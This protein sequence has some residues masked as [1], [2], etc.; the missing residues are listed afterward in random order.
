MVSR[1]TIACLHTY[2]FLASILTQSLTWWN[3]A[4]RNCY[5]ASRLATWIASR[6][7]IIGRN[8]WVAKQESACC[9]TNIAKFFPPVKPGGIT[10]RR[11]RRRDEWVQDP[12]CC[13]ER[14][15]KPLCPPV[16][17]PS[18]TL[19]CSRLVFNVCCVP[20]EDAA[21]LTRQPGVPIKLGRSQSFSKA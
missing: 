16:D 11:Q 3:R 9:T 18:T 19:L 2:N 10:Q 13:K 8:K 20:F 17:T 6:R 1:C 14:Q 21:T 15:W 7:R 4:F 12:Y 5:T